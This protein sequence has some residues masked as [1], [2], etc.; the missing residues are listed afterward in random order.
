MVQSVLVASR[1]HRR[2]RAAPRASVTSRSHRPHRMLIFGMIEGVFSTGN[3]ALQSGLDVRRFGRML[4]VSRY[5]K[6][7]KVQPPTTRGTQ[8]KL[9]PPSDARTLYK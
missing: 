8:I 5:S 2:T 6:N 4:R 1:Y 3:F 9:R 7:T